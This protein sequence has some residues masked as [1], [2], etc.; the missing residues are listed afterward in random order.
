MRPS[1]PRIPTSDAPPN[2]GSRG[3]IGSPLN[4][5][6]AAVVLGISQRHVRRLVS[7]RRI[8]H[9]RVAGSRVRFLRSDLD[10]WLD[11]QRV[12]PVR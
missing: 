5:A 1:V 9:L 4:I 12:E 7:E 3:G 8:P 11:A 2:L 10:R 6:E